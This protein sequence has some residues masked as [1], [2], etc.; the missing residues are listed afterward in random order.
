[1]PPPIDEHA[2]LRFVAIIDSADDA[3]SSADPAGIIQSW[4][5][6]AERLFGFTAEEAIGRS[7]DIVVPP[8]LAAEHAAI[9]AQVLAGETL[10]NVATERQRRDGVRIAIGLTVSPIRGRRGEI[11]GIAAIAR[12]ISDRQHTERTALR[13]A[14]IIQSSDDAIISKDLNGIVTSW[15]ASAERMFGYRADEMIGRSIRTIIPA[16]RQSEEDLVLARIRK[17]ERVEHFETIRQRKDCTTVPISITV[18]PIIDSR[19]VITGA[20]KIARDISERK[21]ADEERARL[22]RTAEEQADVTRTL[23]EVGAAVAS[24]LDRDSVVQTVVDAATRATAAEFGAFFFNPVEVP[25]SGR[26]VVST[27]SKLRYD[28][29]ATEGASWP[30]PAFTG[31][32]AGGVTRVDDVT[33]DSRYGSHPPGIPPGYRPVRSYLSVL[34]AGRAG[35]VLGALVFGHGAPAMFTDRHEQ[36]VVGIAAWASVALENARLYVTAQQASRVKDEFL[37]TLSHE[38]RTPLNAILGYA[39][40]LRQR[41]LAGDKQDRAVETIER[42]ATVLSQIVNDVLDVSRIVTG[43]IRLDMQQVD[44]EELV[45]AA[46]EAVMPTTIAKGVEVELTCASCPSP[47]IGDA[48]RLQQVLW[49]VVSNAVK[50]TESGGRVDV[51]LACTDTE[52]E[53]TVADTGIGIPAEFLPRVFDRFSQH[54]SGPTRERGG[55]GL[56]LSISRDLIERHGGRIEASSAGRG[57]G[58]TFR[59][60][61]PLATDNVSAAEL[62]R[63]GAA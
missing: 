14:A 15:N 5:A 59:I 26:F 28:A 41:V 58:T 1:M 43:K 55:L 22:L 24:A 63:T 18:S 37:A 61:L 29:S 36:L 19:G 54:E 25:S 4:N 53:I 27:L 31:A 32:P 38:L 21:H 56:G 7:I 9:R 23:N 13:L 50:F 30:M 16:D 40:M 34:V 2:A 10:R 60:I 42:N 44:V 49:N 6:G 46:V 52:A 39:R 11:I 33:S 35:E 62:K 47:I 17:G 51:R 12:D 8:D 45:R 3:I 57:H 48:A 20:S